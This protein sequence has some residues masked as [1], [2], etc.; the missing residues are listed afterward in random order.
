MNPAV[1]ARRGRNLLSM[2]EI[3]YNRLIGRE[4]VPIQPEF[5]SIEPTSVCNLKCVFCAYVK[6]DSPKISMKN[7][8]FA[9]YIE[10][11]VAMGYRRFKLTPSTGDIF[12]DRHI[13]D[14]LMFLEE[15]P[16]VEEYQFYTNFTILDA[17]EIARLVSLKKLKY[18]II[19]VYGHDCESFVK[20]AKGT[21]KVYQRLLANLEILL[22]LVEQR[23]GVLE[24]A[25]R[26]ARNMPRTPDTDL[27]KLLSRYK[28]AGIPVRPSHLYH[29]WGGKI[30]SEDLEG[31]AIDV[32]DSSKIYKKG[33]CALLF[34][35]VQIMATGLVH[36]CACVDVDASLKIGDLNERPLRE[37]LSTRNPLYVEIIDEQQRGM[38]RQVCRDC[39][40]YKSI[41]HSRSQ[42][43]KESIP[44]SSIADF[45]VALDAKSE[46]AAR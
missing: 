20:I 45:K 29:S 24:I 10:Q 22:P 27:L 35:G 8:R 33:A 36:A 42:Y 28:A 25:I 18:M 15:H 17:E 16:G 2:V 41:Y 40:F 13:F 9:D 32:T 43:R 6:K 14:K 38:F 7:D 12:M 39:G 23:S 44:T 30:T 46:S 4:I 1:Y 26:S 34:T 21:N 31:I 11:A 3:N 37:I 5:L 19:S